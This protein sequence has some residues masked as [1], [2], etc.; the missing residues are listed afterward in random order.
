MVSTDTEDQA[1]VAL[2]VEM[3]VQ[4][5]YLSLPDNTQLMVKMGEGS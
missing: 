1:L 2:L 4:A 3:K 5:S